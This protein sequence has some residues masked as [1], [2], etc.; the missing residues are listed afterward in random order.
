[1]ELNIGNCF[2]AGSTIVVLNGGKL[3]INGNTTLGQGSGII[4]AI[5]DGGQLIAN[6]KLQI[7]QGTKLIN[8]GIVSCAKELNP[9]ANGSIVINNASLTAKDFVMSNN[10]ELNNYGTANIVNMDL[11]TNNVSIYNEGNMVVTGT[12]VSN[13]NGVTIENHNYIKVDVLD[14][15]HSGIN[16]Q[17]YCR[18]KARQLLVAG[19]S[20]DCFAGSLIGCE[21]LQ[22]ETSKNITLK[23]DAMFAVT[24]LTDFSTSEVG[25]TLSGGTS[26]F[27]G[28]SEGTKT[29]ILIVDVVAN[30]SATN[31]L[32]LCGTLQVVFGSGLGSSYIKTLDSGVT[33]TNTPIIDGTLSSCND[34][35]FEEPEDPEDPTFP[36]EVEDGRT[37]AF[38]M[39][40]NWPEFGDYD[41]NDVV[42]DIYNITRW[43]DANNDVV[44]WGFDIHPRAAGGV[45]S[46]AVMLQFDEISAGAITSLTSSYYQSS[47]EDGQTRENLMIIPNLHRD[48]FGRNSVITNTIIGEPYI[49]APTSTIKATFASAIDKDHLNIDKL[50]FYIFLGN[51]NNDRREVHI[52]GFIPSD[53][54]QQPT[55][56]YIGS[57][58]MVWGFLIPY[59]D[60]LYPIERTEINTAYTKFANWVRTYGMADADWYLY[61]TQGTVY[62][63]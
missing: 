60:F 23:G 43:Q 3:I 22:L 10:S 55:N 1:M 27:S 15:L 52:G 39:E 8:D 41:M 54:V 61:P 12:L 58:G 51:D 50:N 36:I 13:N 37:F 7:N 11:S 40:D 4:I 45:I 6:D 17:N 46:I 16:I 53:K 21:V 63:M 35:Y 14:A 47:V 2:N 30:G 26:E 9:C 44:A 19:G 25:M 33:M 38:A 62:G 24:D 59:S 48:A 5:Q 32:N 42:Y 57:N 28:E 56:N 34:L 49:N 20:I 18:I 29:P 31:M